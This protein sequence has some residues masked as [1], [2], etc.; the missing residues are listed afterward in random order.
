MDS[1]QATELARMNAIIEATGIM[2]FELS[3]DGIIMSMPN[4]M[5]SVYRG[6]ME[7]GEMVRFL[8]KSKYV[9][10]EDREEF[11]NKV[12]DLLDRTEN[13]NFVVRLQ[14]LHRDYAYSKIAI[15]YNRDERGKVTRIF[16]V[17]NNVDDIIKYQKELLYK[18]EYDKLTGLL[19]AETFY[20][21]V[22]NRLSSIRDQKYAMIRMDIDKFK[23]VND[24][25]GMRE[26]DK[27]LQYVAN[28]IIMHT[29]PECLWSRINSDIFSVLF[30]YEGE[31]DILIFIHEVESRL[32]V[33]PIPYQLTMSF[34]ICYVRDKCTEANI[35]CDWAGLALETIKDNAMISYAF[36]NNEIRDKQ[37]RENKLE[38]E[39]QDA[40]DNHEFIVYLQPKYNILTNQMIGAEALVRWLKSDGELI[41]PN[42][43]I[44]LFEKNGFIIQLDGYVWE[45]TCKY[46]RRWKDIDKKSVPISVNVSRNHIYNPSFQNQVIALMEKYKLE[47]DMLELELTESTFVDETKVLYKRMEELQDKGFVFSMDDFGSGYSSLNMLKDAPVSVIK[48]DRGFINETVTSE[49]GIAIIKH[50][51]EMSK[52]LNLKVIAEGV[53]NKEQVELLKNLGCTYAQGF[54]YS[55]PIP[56][57]MFEKLLV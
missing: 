19:N 53:E 49:R 43:F 23:Y 56:V 41:M 12:K 44:P 38:R 36:Y 3:P 5:Y 8:L 27:V 15:F 50:T 17:I 1:R 54:Y 42:D 33:Y 16:C 55:K 57:Q 26:G 18:A 51:V 6:E 9:Y 7:L 31:E 13:Y 39:M 52:H 4:Y 40:L 25:Y 32:H 47:H 22:E 21:K 35:L 2:L 29:G 34:G 45:E 46:L 10:R 37:L 20:Q 30:P 14:I 24:L 48:L 11:S 28:V